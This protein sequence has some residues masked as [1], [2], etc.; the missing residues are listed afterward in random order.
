MSFSKRMMSC[1]I[2]LYLSDSGIWKTKPRRNIGTSDTPK[3]IHTKY[4]VDFAMYM[5]KS[6]L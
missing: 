3:A 4:Y 5:R 1:F 2:R 6:G